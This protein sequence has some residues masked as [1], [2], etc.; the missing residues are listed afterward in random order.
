MIE[1][2]YS[3]TFNFQRG[4]FNRLDSKNR[5]VFGRKCHYNAGEFTISVFEVY[6]C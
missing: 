4:T 1:A 6:L 3:L 5:V 2:S